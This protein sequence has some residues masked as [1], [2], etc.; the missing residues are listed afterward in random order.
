MLEELRE[1]L[2]RAEVALEKRGMCYPATAAISAID[3]EAGLIVITPPVGFCA[4]TPR[5]EEMLV[6]DLLDG[7][8]AEG[9]RRPSADTAVHLHLYNLFPELGAIVQLQ[10]ENVLT[11][12]QA[13]RA[14]PVYGAV[15][16]SAFGGEVPCTRMPAETE[17]KDNGEIFLRAVEEALRDKNREEIPAVLVCGW[18]AFVWGPTPR[19]RRRTP[20][21]WRFLP[22]R[23]GKC[24]RSNPRR[25]HSPLF[26]R[27]I[28]RAQASRPPEIKGTENA[29]PEGRRVNFSGFCR[30][31]A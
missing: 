9:K 25:S 27:E 24:S 20:A 31:S 3:R 7:R 5:A 6:V 30:F 22:E 23:H 11:W 4:E 29:A 14:L 28:C 10:S 15:H 2:Y 21:R 18:G 12:A 1:K 19:K 16:A 13:G 26:C 17:A 8:V